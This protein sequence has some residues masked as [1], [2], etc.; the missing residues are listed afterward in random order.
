MRTRQAANLRKGNEI[1]ID[2]VP[3]TVERV[4]D[5]TEAVDLTVRGPRG[6]SHVIEDVDRDQPFPLH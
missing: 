5:V 4:D 3:V 1:V 6:R 2:G